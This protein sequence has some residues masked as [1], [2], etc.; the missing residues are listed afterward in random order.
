LLGLAAKVSRWRVR[1][2]PN[3]CTQCQL[4]EGSCPFGA[5]RAPVTERLDARQITRERRRFVVLLALVPVLMLAFGWSCSRVSGI[6]AKFHP[7]VELAE[8]YL[9][10]QLEPETLPAV[11]ALAYARAER[12]AETLLDQAI[13]VRRTFNRGG[14]IFGAFAGLVMG[15]SLIR[16]SI[17]S[18]R[19]DFEPDRGA[20]VA[21]ARCFESCPQER[22]RLGTWPSG[23]PLPGIETSTAGSSGK[24]T[25]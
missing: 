19:T 6:A 11:D 7:D 12:D 9:R 20:C 17:Q 8:L 16:F 18:R 5:I 3:I 1:I 2:T 21:C 10:Q 13:E 24:G 22:V 4:C 14:W 25:A 15:A 23:M